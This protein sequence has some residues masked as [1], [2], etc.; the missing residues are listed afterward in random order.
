MH[1]I[2]TY[3]NNLN[4]QNKLRFSYILLIL[5]PVTL[6]CIVYYF[7]AS[8]NILDI[9]RK[10]ILDVTVKNVN[11]IDEQ[12]KAIQTSAMHLNV[13]ADVY[14]VLDEMDSVKDSE[15]L[16]NDKN[17]STVLQKY[18]SNEYVISSN[19]M[20]QRYV[21]GENM[22]L[23]VPEQQF[24]QSKL[25]Q[26]IKGKKG[27]AQ[28]IPTYR[29]EQ[30]FSLDFTVE[31]QMVFSLMQELNPVWIDPEHPN[32]I[33]YLERESDAVLIVNM[34]ESLFRDMFE[35]SNSVKGS[36]YCISTADGKIVVHT[37]EEKNGTEEELPWLKQSSGKQEGSFTLKY[38]GKNVVVCFARSKV[39]GWVAASVTPVNSLLDNV[40]KLQF[41]TILVWILLFVMAMILAAVFSAKITKPVELLVNAMRQV[42]KGNFAL[43]LPVN[44][45]D[46]MQY[47]TE[48]YNEMGEKIETLI[49][50]NYKS[51]IRKKESEIMALNLQLN[52][53]F[54]YNTLNIINMMALEE[55]NMEISKMLISLSDMLQYTFRNKQELVVF[56]EE[57][58]WLQNYLHI[59]KE[60]FEGKFQVEYEI[61]KEIL[62]YKVPKLLL[63][64]LVENA[65][66]HSFGGMDC[67]GILR[68]TGHKRDGKLCFEVCDNGRG[69]SEDEREKAMTASSNRIGLANAIQRI[70]LI[71]G[72]QGE[73]KIDT[74]PS[75]GTRISVILPCEA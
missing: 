60:R 74:A 54:L 18:F 72:E 26:E 48:K 71:Y 33:E 37:D 50:E 34:N 8:E 40:S 68:I 57:Y 30:E 9:A 12:L 32:N 35:N 51:E 55:G 36:F 31:N 67:G 16:V 62:Q 65:I 21:F 75:R 52:P 70:D 27:E 58:I 47:L 22:P 10:N 73:L 23:I 4:L 25:Y 20:T 69:M 28:W 7:V 3:Y 1:K 11:I 56:E 49:E 61:E 2:K 59:M 63:Q 19:I 46:E 44:G 5:V 24:F 66:V 6:L 64:P 53:H 43:R 38:G 41:V 39:T 15:L 42:G 13:D 45:T 14:K 17:L 29:V